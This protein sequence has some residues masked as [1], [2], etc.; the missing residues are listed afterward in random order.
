[1]RKEVSAAVR[2]IYRAIDKNE[3]KERMRKI[4]ERYKNQATK[5]C[6]WLEEHFAEGLT[7]F[8]FPKEHRKKIRT[9]NLMER[10][11]REQ[12]RR[13]R[14]VRLFPGVESCE[15]LVVTIAMRIHEDW[16][17]SRRYLKWD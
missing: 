2:E 13:T 5:F 1:M 9:N 7:F 11:N 15:R 14:T 6:D 3:A 17:T 8:D 10:M 12:K 16:A 4:V